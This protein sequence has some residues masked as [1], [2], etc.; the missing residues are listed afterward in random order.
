MILLQALVFSIS[1]GVFFSQ[2]LKLKTRARLVSYKELAYKAAVLL[3]H[4][5]TLES[6]AGLQE[7]SCAPSGDWDLIDV[8]CGHSLGLSKNPQGI[9][10]CRHI[11][12]LLN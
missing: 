4:V 5:H 11:W 8:G 12:E 10:M 2:S 1:K 7:Y 9:L 3:K 6:P